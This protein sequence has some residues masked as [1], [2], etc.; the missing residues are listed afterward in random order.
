MIY[1]KTIR[2]FFYI[3]IN[4]EKNEK[5]NIYFTINNIQYY[6]I[7]YWETSVDKFL[8]ISLFS[9]SYIFVDIALIMTSGIIIP[10]GM[11]FLIIFRLK[12]IYYSD[13]GY[14]YLYRTKYNEIFIYEQKYLYFKQ[15]SK[16]KYSDNLE[17]LI[18]DIKYAIQIEFENKK[19][20]KQSEDNLKK[21]N[22]F[23]DLKSKKGS[24]IE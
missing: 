20:E 12:K 21:W 2:Y 19:L 13:Y 16:L 17:K 24:H 15:I 18:I 3:C 4:K 6:S 14:F 22:G 23:L 8:S 7:F 1:I 5:N 9:L 10:T 11:V